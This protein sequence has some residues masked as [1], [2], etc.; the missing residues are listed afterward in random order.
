MFFDYYFIL[1][2]FYLFFYKLNIL[3]EYLNYSLY[4]KIYFIKKLI[5]NYKFYYLYL[6]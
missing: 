5:N 1:F 3:K 2:Y 4:I 6:I